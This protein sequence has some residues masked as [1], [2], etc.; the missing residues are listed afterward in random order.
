V[1]VDVSDPAVDL[2]STT[3]L[4]RA[5][6]AHFVTVN[7]VAIPPGRLFSSSDSFLWWTTWSI[8]A[9]AESVGCADHV[10]GLAVEYAKSRKQFG[11]EIYKFQS[12]SHMLADM[13]AR[14]ELARSSVIRLASERSQGQLRNLVAAFGYAVPTL[15]RAVVEDAIQIHGGIGFTWE[16]GLHLWYRRVLQIQAT[17]GG[18]ALAASAAAEHAE[19]GTS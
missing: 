18:P 1:L 2:V 17:L 7:K 9:L 8:A 13:K 11:Q 10:L 6:G 3:A 15:A 12:V 14:V 19:Q 16:Q 4:D 5:Q